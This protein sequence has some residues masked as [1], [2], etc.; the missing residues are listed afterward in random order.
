MH[1][2]LAVSLFALRLD[3]Y[4]A[5]HIHSVSLGILGIAEYLF[6]DL[7]ELISIRFSLI[8]IQLKKGRASP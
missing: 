1:A 3:C 7:S 4:D 6:A 5:A 8:D 2:I